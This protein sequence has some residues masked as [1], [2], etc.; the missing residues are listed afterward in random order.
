MKILLTL[1]TSHHI[2]R[3][4]RLVRSVELQYQDPRVEV[5]TIIV[6]NTKNDEYYRQVISEKFPYP[7]IRTESNGWPGKGKNSCIDIFLKSNC[8]F[9]IQQDGDELF[10]PTFVQ[11]IADHLDRYGASI[12]ILG[13][14]PTEKVTEK[15]LH[16]GHEFNFRD[17]LWLTV[18]GVSAVWPMDRPPGPCRGTWFDEEMPINQNT[19]VLRSKKGAEYRFV[20]DLPNGEDA[21]C[22]VELLK[23][24]QEGKIN[25]FLSMSSD[26]YVYDETTPD[27]IQKQFPWADWVHN[28]RERVEKII[29]PNRSNFM[30][31]PMIYNPLRMNP[32]EK[33]AW[34]KE[35]W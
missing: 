21:L 6:V 9:L 13:V 31:L 19:I 2:H 8:D 1:L 7:V 29:D 11:S 25:Y 23:A 10:Y 28:W 16:A 17:N 5:V 27:S 4:K 35:H 12:D 3:L 34:V 30:E 24:H 14:I 33:E 22:S 18:W 20:E 15:R 32:A 26:W